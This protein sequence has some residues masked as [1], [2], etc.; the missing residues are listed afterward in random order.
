MVDGKVL[1]NVH[2]NNLSPLVEKLRECKVFKSGPKG[3]HG[4]PLVSIAG[5]L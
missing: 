5:G 4:E 3:E 2:S 1:G